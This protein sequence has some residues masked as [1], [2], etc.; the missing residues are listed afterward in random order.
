[1]D[2][3]AVAFEEIKRQTLV[4]LQVFLFFTTTFYNLF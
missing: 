1:M 3:I 4:D 2:Y